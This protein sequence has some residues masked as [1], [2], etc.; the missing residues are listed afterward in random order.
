[1]REL[2]CYVTYLTL[3][4]RVQEVRI[5]QQQQQKVNKLWWIDV[6]EYFWC[7]SWSVT[8][9]FIVS[10]AFVVLLLEILLEL[11]KW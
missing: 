3:L 5:S 4:T 11:I 2:F 9:D 7:R 6:I 10:L 1:V 8:Y